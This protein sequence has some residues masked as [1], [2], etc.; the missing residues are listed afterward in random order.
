[1]ARLIRTSSRYA[2]TN[3][4][5]TVIYQYY[6]SRESPRWLATWV[7][8]FSAKHEIR[9]YTRARLAQRLRPYGMTLIL[10]K[11]AK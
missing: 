5:L 1:M 6:L 10:A 11:G 7:D 3:G 2:W 8:H 9:E 4:N